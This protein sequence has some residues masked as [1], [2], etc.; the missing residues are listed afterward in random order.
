MESRRPPVGRAGAAGGSRA[1]CGRRTL[2]LVLVLRE[3][4]DALQPEGGGD[5]RD[6]CQD[7]EARVDRLVAAGRDVEEPS[8]KTPVPPYMPETRETTRALAWPKTTARAAISGSTPLA[9]GRR[10]RWAR[11]RARM[12]SAVASRMTAITA[13]TIGAARGTLGRLPRE[14][15]RRAP[16][17]EST[18][19]AAKRPA[20]TPSL[21]CFTAWSALR[22][23][24]SV[25][26]VIR[27]VRGRR[28]RRSVSAEPNDYSGRRSSRSARGST[29]SWPTSVSSSVTGP[30][31]GSWA[32]GSMSCHGARTKARS[33][34]LGWGGS[35]PG[36][37]R[38]R[39]RTPR[40]R[41]R[42]CAGPSAPR[43]PGRRPPR[44]PG[45]APGG[46][47]GGALSSRRSPR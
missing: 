32:P 15:Q 37:R 2:V 38:R 13:S 22:R 45:R 23:Q 28:R 17:Q 40:C 27:V 46:R 29:P 24:S 43:G 33:W 21:S 18:P 47:T 5:H 26:P 11:S 34:A 19:A 30:A 42:W 16:P 3:L 9:P 8:R 25:S 6:A 35:A 14:S 31:P 20:S 7:R 4:A 10:S 36:R 41:R 12:E 1:L 44:W 39:P